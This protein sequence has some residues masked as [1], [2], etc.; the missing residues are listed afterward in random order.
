[1]RDGPGLPRARRPWPVPDGKM[2]SACGGLGPFCV[3]NLP[4]ATGQGCRVRGGP[5]PSRM[6]KGIARAVALAHWPVLYG[7]MHSARGGPGPFCAVKYH[8]R[9]ARAAA[10][11]AALARS[12]LENPKCVRR[13]WP[14]PLENIPCA[15]GPEPPRARRPWPVLYWKMHS[16]C[17]GPGPFFA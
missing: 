17:G 13:P 1:M 5:G 6:G 4:C 10:R 8:A 14:S 11:A 9:G 12:A 2:H 16:A 15:M 3:G 7:I